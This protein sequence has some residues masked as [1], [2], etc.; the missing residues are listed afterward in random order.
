MI[1]IKSHLYRLISMISLICANYFQNLIITL[2]HLAPSSSSALNSPFSSNSS[3]VASNSCFSY[4]RL[5]VWPDSWL[6]LSAHYA[7]QLLSG[8]LLPLLSLLLD[9]LHSLIIILE[10]QLH[11]FIS[12]RYNYNYFHRA[13]EYCSICGSPSS[14]V[15]SLY[16]LNCR[17]C[18]R[19]SFQSSRSSGGQEFALFGSERSLFGEAL[20]EVS[21]L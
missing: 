14:A 10:S 2:S 4:P 17:A 7:P 15:Y 16:S 12:H 5:P 19:R 13:T 6:P 3:C 9:L 1:I 18:P 20:R 8:L 21:Q 11:S